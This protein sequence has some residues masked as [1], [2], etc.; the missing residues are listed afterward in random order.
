MHKLY[1]VEKRLDGRI[2]GPF[3]YENSF[4][5]D[6][7]KLEF[8]NDL[9]IKKLKNNNIFSYAVWRHPRVTLHQDPYLREIWFNLIKN[10]DTQSWLTGT[11]TLEQLAEWF[12]KSIR[13]SIDNEGFMVV[14]YYFGECHHGLRQSIGRYDTRTKHQLVGPLEKILI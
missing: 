1:R 11:K 12:P 13:S 9:D 4:F 6:L 3:C 8:V 7:S 14:K 10:N 5:S 2:Y